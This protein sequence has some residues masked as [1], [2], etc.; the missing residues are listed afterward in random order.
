M[1][2]MIWETEYIKVEQGYSDCVVISDLDGSGFVQMDNSELTALAMEWLGQ[3][4]FDIVKKEPEI[5]SCP[6][7]ECGG[8]CHCDKRFLEAYYV[9]CENACGY[10]GPRAQI[11]DKAIRLHNLIAGEPND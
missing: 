11:R 7:P 2:K 10:Q 8:E 1:S 6:N 5:K 3:R 9:E 4:G